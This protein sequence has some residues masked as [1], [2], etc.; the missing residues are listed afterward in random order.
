MR[1]VTFE[2]P[3]SV[4]PQRRTGALSG[5][6][7]VDLFAARA[8]QHRHAGRRAGDRLAAAEL[9]TDMLGLLELGEP[10]LDAAREAVAHA[11]VHG[12]D[13]APARISYGPDEVWLLA[14]IPRPPSLRDFMVAEEHVRRSF[15][16]DPP[17]EWW[18]IPVYYKG[19][20]EEIYGP[21]DTIPWPAY[22][23]K[24]DYELE[25]CAVIGASGR[26]V[27]ADSADELIV[28]YTIYNDW[29][30]R[31]IQF[32][33]M[34]VGIGPGY[35]K[36]FGSSL[37]PCIVTRDEFDAGAKLEA[38]ID[39]EVWSSGTLGTMHFSFA[40]I[41]AWVSQEQTLRPG[42]LLGSGTVGGGCGL[43]LDRWITEGAV[44]ELEA[45]GI[46]VLRNYV[47]AKGAGPVRATERHP[48]EQPVLATVTR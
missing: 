34:S 33:E 23:E 40:E 25:I 2:V 31:D 32:R 6:R 43:E 9:A 35:G 19:N 22:T 48:G 3:S 20:C 17:A 15:K 36:D 11:D 10:A 37:G 18:N 24:L 38:R 1:L 4:G 5:G 12:E 29:S 27:S 47:S 30:A 46:G 13:E 44:V 39:G 28:G 21:E 16:N 26:N 14:P 7:V 45:E 8:D 42:D 41:I